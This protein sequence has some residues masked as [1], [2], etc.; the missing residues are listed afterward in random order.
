M[1]EKENLSD[2]DIQNLL[3]EIKK[4]RVEHDSTYDKGV[5]IDNAL[6]CIVKEFLSSFV[7]IG[8]DM[9]GDTVIIRS[10]DSQMS[11]DALRSSLLRYLQLLLYEE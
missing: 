11:K 10:E 6:G 7:L 5:D 8:Y 9:Q 1:D 2:S 3:E 4:M